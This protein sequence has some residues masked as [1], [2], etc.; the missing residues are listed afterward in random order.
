MAT[1]KQRINASP[2]RVFEVLADGWSYSNWV[3]GTSHMMAVEP[4]WPQARSRLFHAT[5][6]WPLTLRDETVV[7]EVEPDRLL[8]LTARG[9]PLGEATIRLELE[10]DGDGGCIVTM[11]EVPTAGSARLMH[12][13]L[14]DGMLRVRN[15]ESLR[16]LAGLAERRTAPKR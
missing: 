14:V 6:V 2:H 15:V 8:A 13:K 1:N 4:E 5:G 3:V 10:D 16:R 12:N 11:Q 7:D 9:W